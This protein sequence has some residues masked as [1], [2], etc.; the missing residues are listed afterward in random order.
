VNSERRTAVESE[1]GTGQISEVPLL[2]VLC[3]S[4]VK[5]P[6]E[7]QGFGVRGSA[8]GRRAL[9]ILGERVKNI[10]PRRRQVDKEEYWLN[11]CRWCDREMG[12]ESERFSINTKFRDPKD[13]RKNAGKIVEFYVP[14]VYRS[15]M[16]FAVTRDSEAKKQGYEIMFVICSERCREELSAA[17]REDIT[18]SGQ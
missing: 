10:M 6:L 12:E 3:V 1:R 13:Y 9:P 8:F 7:P 14:S 2:C 18:G 17:L 5:F 4:E 16:A 11:H 15:I